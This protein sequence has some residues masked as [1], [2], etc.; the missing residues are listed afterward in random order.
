MHWDQQRSPRI[1]S[2]PYVFTAFLI[3]ICSQ[4]LSILNY[5]CV[6]CLTRMC[7]LI[8]LSLQHKMIHSMISSDTG[9]IF[10]FNYPLSEQLT[11]LQGLVTE[12]ISEAKFGWVEVDIICAYGD[13]WLN[14]TSEF[15]TFRSA[16][17]ISTG[18]QQ[19]SSW[20]PFT[21]W[22]PDNTNHLFPISK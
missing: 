11:H 2:C 4:C 19:Y 7:F 8:S 12:F 13:S 14:A 5:C 6:Q 9:C 18:G 22:K 10:R 16:G 17:G 15:D 1:Y 20:P 21:H 3:R